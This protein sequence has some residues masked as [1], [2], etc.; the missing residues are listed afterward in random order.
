[1]DSF[2]FQIASDCA[3]GDLGGIFDHVVGGVCGAVADQEIKTDTAENAW[4][5]SSLRGR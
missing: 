2:V 1:M 3:A 4:G 5:L